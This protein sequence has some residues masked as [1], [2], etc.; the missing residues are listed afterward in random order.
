MLA[1]L[2][3]VIFM[4]LGIFGVFTWWSSFMVVLKGLLP[5][6]IIFGGL[7]SI[8]AG[9]SKINERAAAKESSDKKE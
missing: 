8:V 1:I 4:A 7:L 6:L 9:A 3:G 2:F 5:F